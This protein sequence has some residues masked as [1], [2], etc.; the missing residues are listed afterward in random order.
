ML[1]MPL[2][3]SLAAMPL[4]RHRPDRFE[5]GE[6]FGTGLVIT[7]GA[8][9]GSVFGAADANE[10]RWVVVERVVVDVVDNMAR[11]NLCTAIR[12]S[13][14]LDVELEETLLAVGVAPCLVVNAA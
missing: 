2:P 9:D 11:R 12:M 5:V 13:P 3:P 1:T 4:G 7:T 14:Y 6:V 10:V 8:M